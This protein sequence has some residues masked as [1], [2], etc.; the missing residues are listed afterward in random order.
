MINC[1]FFLNFWYLSGTVKYLQLFISKQLLGKVFLN[2]RSLINFV[3]S[4]QYLGNDITKPQ[5]NIGD[6]F[7]Q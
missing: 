7:L 4:G 3:I 2:L 5:Q 1:V 6:L